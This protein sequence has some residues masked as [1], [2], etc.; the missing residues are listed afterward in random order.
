VNFHDD[1][2]AEIRFN[3]NIDATVVI[4]DA[5]IVIIDAI[6]V[7]IGVATRKMD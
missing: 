3:A 2:Q 7:I 5:I 1:E 6:I 4:I